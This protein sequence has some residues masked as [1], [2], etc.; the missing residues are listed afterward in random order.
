VS[1]RLF[2]I[3]MLTQL[4]RRKCGEGMGMLSRAYNNGIELACVIVEP[5]KVAIAACL[6][7]PHSGLIDCRIIHVTKGHDVF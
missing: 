2:T 7:L 3:D 5:T 6:R 4:Q 1:E